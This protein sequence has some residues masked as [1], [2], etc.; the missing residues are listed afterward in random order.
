MKTHGEVNA[1]N[2]SQKGLTT[3]PLVVQD[4]SSAPKGSQTRDNSTHEKNGIELLHSNINRLEKLE[5]RL[6]R[7]ERH[8]NRKK[9]QAVE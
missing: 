7:G 2:A 1:F 5:R 6:M 9:S 8:A 4:Q 3:V